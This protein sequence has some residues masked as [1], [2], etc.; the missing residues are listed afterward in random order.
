M[1]I[2]NTIKPISSAPINGGQARPGRKSGGGESVQSGPETS[3]LHAIESAMASTPA[4]D[5]AKVEEIKRAIAEGRFKVN[6]DLVA[7]RLLDTVREML[8]SRK[9]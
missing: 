6:P 2:D 1:K 3:Q 8:M 9:P 4:F 5:S 7:E